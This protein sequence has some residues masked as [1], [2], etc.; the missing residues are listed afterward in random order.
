MADEAAKWRNLGLIDDRQADLLAERYDARGSAR[1]ILLKWL[2]FFGMFMLG[3]A[4]LG[5]VGVIVAD[6]G[7]AVPAVLLTIVAGAVG[8]IGARLA[9]D[10]RRRYP[11]VGSALLTVSLIMVYGAL[12]L[13]V[14]AFDGDLERLFGV[15]LLVIA[16]AAF[17]VAYGFRLRWPL[18]LALLFFFHGVGAWNAYG[19]S[20]AYFADIADPQAM[21]LIALL[22]IGFGVHHESVLEAGPLRRHVGFGGLYLVFGLLYLDVSLWFLTLPRPTLTW[23]LT[24]AG[25][26]IAQIVA[27]A[28]LK[29]SRFTGFGIVFLSINLYTRL[30]EHYWDR[31]SAGAFFAV[32]GLAA[33]ALGLLFERLGNRPGEPA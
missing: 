8:W 22:V 24:F 5:F 11:V 1:N 15:L 31:L 33:L 25:A 9:V 29:D 6:S 10:P 20:G 32:A 12:L 3:S 13:F 14:G 30:F 26:A 7:Y 21:A 19:G 18:L 23:V 27:G 17:A 16:A 28:A 2:G 4:V